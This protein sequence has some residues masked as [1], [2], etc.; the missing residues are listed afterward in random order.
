MF[1]KIGI[2]TFIGIS[3]TLI[4]T[5]LYINSFY[6]RNYSFDYLYW[7]GGFLLGLIFVIIDILYIEKRDKIKILDDKRLTVYAKIVLVGFAALF[8]GS[9][10]LTF[11]IFYFAFLLY[12]I[13]CL[14]IFI[15]S[16]II[17]LTI[18]LI[19]IRTPSA[20]FIESKNMRV[21][22][23]ILLVL[24]ILLPV[25]LIQDMLSPTY[26][27]RLQ[28]ERLM[29]SSN[30]TKLFLSSCDGIAISPEVDRYVTIWDNYIFSTKTGE[31]LMHE[32]SYKSIYSCISPGG[33]YIVND[34]NQTIISVST[35]EIIGKYEDNFRSWSQNE[36]YFTTVTDNSIIVWNISNFSIISFLKGGCYNNVVMSPNGSLIM[37]SG[38]SNNLIKM[39]EV[40]SELDSVIW[41]KN[42]GKYADIVW[43]ETGNQLQIIYYKSTENDSKRYQLLILNV[44]N[45]QEL[46]NTSFELTGKRIVLTAFDLYI[47]YDGGKDKLLF[48]NSSV[49][50]KE[51]KIKDLE[52][53]DLSYDRSIMAWGYKN[54]IVEI[55]NA[56]SGKLIRTIKTPI[57]EIVKPTP[58]FE[59]VAVLVAIVFVLFWKR[60][61]SN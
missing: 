19:L 18:F 44:S 11:F 53:F 47:L 48:Y 31:I 33:N 41:Q 16:I 60:K 51:Y 37:I 38:G 1:K 10:L 21:F 45:G 4:W 56:S 22:Y 55:R 59:I 57:Y 23:V 26:S 29:L 20:K 9:I 7:I 54:G 49:L 15:P 34:L 12:Y 5:I 3:I 13:I 14:T 58:G 52:E 17:G 35:G 25:I 28:I 27:G 42:V 50:M 2:F 30:G 36:N 40:F 32:K 43:S 8:I 39:Q 61:N 6:E 24:I 46:Y